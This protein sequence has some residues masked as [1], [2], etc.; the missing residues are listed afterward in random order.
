[1]Y[2]SIRP[3]KILYDTDGNRVQAHG[4]SI[5]F[6]DGTFYFYGENKDNITGMAT[7][8]KCKYWHHG[9]NVYSSKD[10][11]NWKYEGQAV[12]ESD[13]ENDAFHP[14]NIMD[15]PHILYNEKTKKF[16]LYAKTVVNGDFNN[17]LFSVC[18]GDSIINL[19]HI[20]DIKLDPT[21]AGDFDMF[22]E[23]DKAYIIYENPHKNMIIRELTDDYLNVKENYTEHI[24]RECPPFVRE[25]PA[26]FKYNNRM[27]ILTSGTTGYFPNSTIS[28]DITN[29]NGEWKELGK[30]CVNDINNNSFNS[31]FSSVFKHPYKKNL[32]IALGDRWLKDLP[33]DLP[34]MDD[35]FMN[36]F[37]NG[38]DISEEL[39]CS[40]ENTSIAD[41]VWLP[42][43]FNENG[44][45]EIHWK[46][47][48]KI[49]DFD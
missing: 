12:K 17:C 46:R 10:L 20:Y 13:D 18:V 44:N 14:K 31:Q 34:N 7:G 1:M 39:S 21:H 41:Y 29:L 35:A 27:F 43:T 48:W 2:N 5:L 28:Y 22:I 19:K 11:Y 26:Y 40:D 9:V 38:I 6:Y 47:N 49:E 45:P 32:Y 33:V 30:T 37:K 3:G 16:V 24:E 36:L 8:E 25:A 4:G 15:R 23:N 42:I